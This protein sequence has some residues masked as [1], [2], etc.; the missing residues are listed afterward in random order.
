MRRQNQVEKMLENLLWS[1]R[2]LTIIPVFFGMMSVVALFWL[3]S[4]EIIHGLTADTHLS[5]DKAKYFAKIISGIIGGIDV[6]LI[7][8]VLM[9]FSFGIYELFIAK[10]QVARVHHDI[11]ILEIKSLDQLKDKVLKVIVM[12]L[13]VSFFKTVT[14]MPIKTPLDLLYLAISILLIAASSY[15]LRNF[16][17]HKDKHHSIE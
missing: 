13:V 4:L 1:M 17:A 2:L 8:I 7:G 5:E 14:E 9:L 10:I 6:Y 16:S 15:L 12:V 11:K 3:G